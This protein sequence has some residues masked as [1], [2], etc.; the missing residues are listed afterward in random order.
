M[1]S[2]AD[3]SP[4]EL[5]T[6]VIPCSGE[7]D[8]TQSSL[9]QVEL[10]RTVSNRLFDAL[11]IFIVLLLSATFIPQELF[12]APPYVGPIVFLVGVI[13]AF[14]S[15]QR[16]LKNL[17]ISDLELLAR[18]WR[19]VCL[20]P[21]V[22]GLLA[23]VLYVLFLSQMVTGPMFPR[24]DK[25]SGEAPQAANGLLNLFLSYSDDPKEYAKLIFWAFLAG[26]SEK[27]VIDIL[28]RFESKGPS[29]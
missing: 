24:F 3:E 12:D 19:Y 20:S 29:P 28:G 11:A 4:A 18:S 10:V 14:V 22:G 21:V 7:D 23:S 8:M 13:G 17:S 25:S 27:F 5:A 26:F 6:K 15:L 2:L 9:A 16:R 1:R